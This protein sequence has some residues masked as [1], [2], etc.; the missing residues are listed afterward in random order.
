M[1]G[2]PNRGERPREGRHNTEIAT[3]RAPD[4]LQVTLEIARLKSLN[5]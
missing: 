3:T 1:W 5:W 2:T 4:G